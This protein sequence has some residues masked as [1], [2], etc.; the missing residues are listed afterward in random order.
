M[1]SGALM[2]DL[3]KILISF[4]ASEIDGSISWIWEGDIV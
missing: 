1:T 4:H 3:E 2:S